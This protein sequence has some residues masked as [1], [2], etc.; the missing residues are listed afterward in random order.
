M[1]LMASLVYLKYPARWVDKGNISP[2]SIFEFLVR[3]M[4]R[5]AIDYYASTS[6]HSALIVTGA[7]EKGEQRIR[8]NKRRR[9]LGG[10]RKSN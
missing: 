6:A 1:R 2:I 5:G 7:I 3:L 9:R 8:K 10:E 4:C